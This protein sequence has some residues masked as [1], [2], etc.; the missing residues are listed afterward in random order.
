MIFPALHF[1]TRLGLT[2]II[3]TA[4][5]GCSTPEEEARGGMPGFM[6]GPV[7]VITTEVASKPFVDRYTALGTARA[8]ESIE[9]TSRIS[10]V[11]TRINFREGQAVD[12][13]RILIQLESDEI[14]A[15]LAMAEA[16][17]EQKR[18][19]YA[20]S[21]QLSQTRAVSEAELDQLKADELMAQARVE[22][23]RA[24][25]NH[26]TIR[27]PFAGTVGL[28][29]VSP[30]DL[31]GP[32]TVITTLDATEVIKLEFS[33]PEIFL[34]DVKVDMRIDANT[35]V[36]PASVFSGQVASIDPRVDPISR[37]VLIRAEIPNEDSRLKPGMFLTVDLV[38]ERDDVLMIPEEALVPRQGRQYV[39]VV[40]EDRARERQVELGSRAPGMAEIREGLLPGDVVIVEG[41]QKV[42]DGAEVRTSA[43]E[44]A[45]AG[46]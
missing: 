39:F 26:A 9:V 30:G 43:S 35:D 2:A 27:A 25:L 11:V 13:G 10:S 34:R 21:R 3:A 38:K 32:D 12:K 6:G 33:V 45:A 28:R 22:S 17:L 24:R 29:Q 7:R 8:M 18:S 16:E 46:G 19:Q 5:T 1:G 14:A 23:S 20:R 42:R 41:T 36:Y 4:I 15:D 44:P 40:E 31:V 37:S